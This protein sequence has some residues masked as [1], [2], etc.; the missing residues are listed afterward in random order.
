MVKVS[1]LKAKGSDYCGVDPRRLQVPKASDYGSIPVDCK[2]ESFFF[3]CCK[4][5]IMVV[6]F[7]LTASEKHVFLF[8]CCRSLSV[9]LVQYNGQSGLRC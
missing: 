2:R 8:P 4:S 1:V 7:Q 9:G 5:P 3:P 6:Q